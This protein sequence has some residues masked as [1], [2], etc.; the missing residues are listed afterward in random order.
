MAQISAGSPGRPECLAK[1]NSQELGSDD[2]SDDSPEPA[3]NGS[4]AI[5]NAV[6][7]AAD[8]SGSIPIDEA[9][10][11]STNG[12]TEKSRT[13]LTMTVEMAAVNQAIMSLTGQNPI[14]IK[15]EE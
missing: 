1:L 13:A 4:Q 2:I 6:L 9:T 7:A 8:I 11:F 15:N 14:E 12:E 5:E 10:D 3:T